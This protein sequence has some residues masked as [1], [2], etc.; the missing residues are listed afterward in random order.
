MTEQPF[1]PWK[2]SWAFTPRYE[3][4]IESLEVPI[5]RAYYI[6]DLRTIEVSP[7]EDQEVN[8]AVVVLEGNKDFMETRLGDST[9]GHGAAHEVQPG[10]HNLRRLRLR[11]GNRVV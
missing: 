10:R 3:Q 2:D 4:W 9:G 6:D 5:H 8:T 1:D 11:N 7:W